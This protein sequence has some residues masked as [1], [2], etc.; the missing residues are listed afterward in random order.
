MKIINIIAIILYIA[1]M[2][3]LCSGCKTRKVIND[4]VQVTKSIDKTQQS[5][6]HVVDSSKLVDTTKKIKETHTERENTLT[7]DTEFKADSAVTTTTPDGTTKTKF[8]INGNVKT[9]TQQTGKKTTDK[10]ETTKKGITQ[11]AV[12]KTDSLGKSH[13]QLKTDST[14]VH[15]DTSAIG[16]GTEWPKWVGIALI[17]AVISFFI[18]R[19]ITRPKIK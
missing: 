11:T 8:Y 17:V 2:I 3:E 13:E 12:S 19:Y 15:K 14:N 10:K 6:V 18:Y 4:K 16:S 9:R 5:Q 7:S 1:L